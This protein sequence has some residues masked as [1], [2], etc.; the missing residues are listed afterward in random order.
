[1]RSQ[2]IS[3]LF[4]AI[5]LCSSLSLAAGYVDGELLLKW[6]DGPQSSAAVAANARMGSTVIR[7]F[8]QIGWQQVKLPAG[9]SVLE[10]IEEYRKLGVQWAEANA[11]TDPDPPAIRD[12]IQEVPANDLEMLSPFQGMEFSASASAPL[13]PNDPMFTK[14]WFWKKINAPNAWAVTTG[15]SNIVVAILDGG[16]NYKHEDLAANMWRNPGEIPGNGIDDDGNG[17]VDDVYGIDTARDDR[18][19]DSDPFDEGS[20]IGNSWVYH[21]SVCAGLIGA[22]G[23]NS[24]GIAGLNWSVQLMAVRVTRTNDLDM[25]ADVVAGFDYVV[26]MK[27]RGVNIRVTSNS[28]GSNPRSAYSRALEDAIEI[29]GREGI[30]NVFA[31][32]NYGLDINRVPFYPAR[33][34]SSSMIVVANSDKL[35]ALASDSN[36]GRTAVDLAA[37]GEDITST[38]GPASNSYF[39]GGHGTSFATPLVAGTAA[40]LL[41]INPNLT[42]DELK[43]AIFGS[44]DQP[45]T[46]KGKVVT[47]G[48]LNVARALEFVTNASAPP[49]IVSAQP[50]SLRTPADAPLQV[51]FNR[52]MNR[53][54]V[55][56]ALVI[57]P[58]LAGTFEWSNDSRSFVFRHNAPF[59]VMANY[60][61]RVLGTAQDELGRTL[62]GNF[63]RA[64]DGSPGDDFLWSIYLP[65]LNDD[66]ADAQLL[67]G[68]SG[69]VNGNNRYSSTEPGEPF[70][71][72]TDERTQ[73][74]TLW[75]GWTP[76]EG[77]GWFTFDLGTRTAFDALLAIYSGDHLDQLLTTA[78]NDNY[79]AR[80]SSRLSFAAS[81]GTP[82]AISVASKSAFDPNQAGN[83]TLSWYPTPPPGFTGAQ[84]SPPTAAPGAKVTLTGTNF[85]GAT[86]VLFNGVPSSFDNAPTNNIDLR[87]TATVPAN[88]ISGPITIITPHGTVTSSS[89]FIVVGP[90]LHITRSADGDVTLTWS[91]PT[92]RL[93][94]SGDLRS[95]KEVT[96]SSGT[97]LNLH[98][99]ES[100]TFFRLRGQ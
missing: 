93:E 40:L 83:F 70:H 28:Y 51:T 38:F 71:I 4:C 66:F 8:G 73:G 96:T 6:K 31:A 22:V 86:V 100:H 77:D 15:S 34:E 27:R 91:D 49:I 53:N 59:D 76:P 68:A 69:F 45:T 88:A 63:N 39:T 10:G 46:L 47:N 60:T 17:Y 35:D 84:F 64:A 75:Y 30:L 24:K 42:V 13:T 41:S 7:N 67:T 21:G 23:N 61:V 92:V 74:R 3:L 44:V 32:D 12:E 5:T 72:L 94:S 95:W 37:P 14:Q 33:Y 20:S 26:L 56:Q 89:S 98:P 11:K 52:P 62:D 80:G 16:I 25:I 57:Q 54:S 2:R 85:T 43:A 1:M 29:A 97:G 82:Y 55:E 18:G 79:G 50:R 9:T 90:L 87:I 36:F 58:P 78:A 48:R 65:I 19:N 81:S 99:T